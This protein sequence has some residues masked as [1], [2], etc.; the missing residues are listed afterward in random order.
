[1]LL[2]LFLEIPV[3]PQQKP[4]DLTDKSIEDL[5][6]IE[7]TSVSKKEQKFSQTAAA[8]FVITQEDIRRSGATNIPDLLRMVPGMDVAQINAHTWAISARGNNGRFS[9]DLLVLV[10]GRTVYTPTFGGV[11]WDVF[12]V[13]LEDIERIEVIRGPGGAIWGANA[14][15]G[16]INV[17]TKKAGETRGGMVVAGGGNLD[18]G[19]GTLQYGGGIGE[20]TNYRV[21]G[22]YSNQSDLPNLEGQSGDDGWRVLRGGF[23]ADSVLSSKDILTVQGD[24][25]SGRE[26]QAAEFLPSITSA[27]TQYVEAVV[28]LSGGYFQT[29]WNHSFSS[30][31]DTSLMASYDEYS[32]SDI[33]GERRGTFSFD[34]QH[35]ILWGQRQEIVWGVNYRD[36]GSTTTGSLYVSLHPADL[37]TQLFGGFV[38]DQ[39]ALV[40]DRLNLTIGAKLEH[41]YYTGFGA[42]PNVRIAWTPATNQTVWAAVSR[43]LRTPA[44]IDASIRLNFGG[45]TGAGGTPVLV[46]LFGSQQ[47][48]D[49]EVIAYET[50]YRA[51]LGN[52]LSL[53]IA[54]YYNDEEHQETSEPGALFFETT[55]APPHLVMPLTY[56][57]LMHGNAYGLEVSANWKVSSRW[58]LSPGYGFERVHMRLDASS[59]DTTSVNAEEGSAPVHSGQLRSHV[60]LP[61]HLAWDASAYFVDRI[62]D[63]MIPSYTRLDTGLTWQRGE[64]LSFSLVGQNLLKNT[65]FE[66][67]D[68]NGSTE[69]SL[70]KRSGYAKVTWHF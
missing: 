39:I 38:Q 63:P 66:Y 54:A 51:A 12:D 3:W 56:E 60:D 33:L 9:N 6:N 8:I 53:D 5:M 44:A 31:S 40:P 15:N 23:R 11:F 50:G 42:M 37:N 24:L 36:S 14:V 55:P 35:H 43:A 59:H 46:S 4:A 70:V 7:V 64:G 47:I 13:P 19:F 22:K 25:Y 18:Q 49:E 32:R 27:A 34:F 1:M 20:A 52:A 61:H 41:N 16:V 45:F 17:I 21:Y 65:H 48:Q 69:P 2:A 68:L 58:T 57:N 62:A 30:R 29:T 10:D 67:Y 26:R 28:N